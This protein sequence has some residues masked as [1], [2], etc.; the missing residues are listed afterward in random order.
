MDVIKLDRS[1][2]TQ[3]T[4]EAPCPAWLGGL[5]A[6]LHSAR[7]EVIAE[8]VETAE[9][10]AALRSAGVAMA[11]G[12]YFSRPLRAEGLT[13]YHAGAGGPPGR[14]EPGN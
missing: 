6:L 10:V 7:V 1:L 13:A 2:V 9:Q 5:S 12:Y 3:I 14:R 8:G 4:P 11:Q